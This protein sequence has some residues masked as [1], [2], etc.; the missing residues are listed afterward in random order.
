MADKPEFEVAAAEVRFR[1]RFAVD[2]L[3]RLGLREISMRGAHGADSRDMRQR[4]QIGE[5]L[6]RKALAVPPD[7][8]TGEIDEIVRLN[9][10]RH[11][12]VVIARQ[13]RRPRRPDKLKRFRRLRTVSDHVSETQEP[14]RA[15][16]S[17]IFEDAFKGGDVGMDIRKDRIDHLCII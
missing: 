14:L 13:H 16:R 11:S 9:T 2:V 15:H 1:S 4:T 6:G 7:G 8:F 5:L 12:V 3:E 10:S 17:C